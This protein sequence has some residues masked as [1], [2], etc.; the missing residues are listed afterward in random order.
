MSPETHKLVARDL[1]RHDL[2]FISITK[3]GVGANVQAFSNATFGTLEKKNPI[4]D[5][6]VLFSKLK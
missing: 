2:L 4:Y 1:T 6:L 5:S 3:R